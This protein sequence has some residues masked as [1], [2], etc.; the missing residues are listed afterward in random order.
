[1]LKWGHVQVSALRDGA[2]LDAVEVSNGKEAGQNWVRGFYA[3][4]QFS[5]RAE[6]PVPLDVILIEVCGHRV[7]R[8]EC[9]ER[10]L[11]RQR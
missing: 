1:M 3:I 8:G 4:P 2:F 11:N 6:Q 10:H 5:S 9:V 7:S